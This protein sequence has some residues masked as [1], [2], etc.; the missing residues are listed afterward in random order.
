MEED[1]VQPAIEEPTPLG[2][3]K[4]ESVD[5]NKTAEQ[6][7]NPDQT[8]NPN[9][10]VKAEGVEPSINP[11]KVPSSR[12]SLGTTGPKSPFSLQGDGID[13]ARQGFV[14][15]V[16]AI[17]K[18]FS[19]VDP[20]EVGDVSVGI[21]DFSKTGPTK[22]E[23]SAH[24]TIEQ[25]PDDQDTSTT[26]R[27]G[28]K[29]IIYFKG[30]EAVGATVG[31]EIDPQDPTAPRLGNWDLNIPGMEVKARSND[32]KN[33]ME[34]IW[35]KAALSTSSKTTPSTA[36]ITK[37]E[38][39]VEE[40][41]TTSKISCVLPKPDKNLDNVKFTLNHLTVNVKNELGGLT[42]MDVIWDKAASPT[43]QSSTPTP[44]VAPTLP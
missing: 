18:D 10:T 43:P 34:L 38:C 21:D 27:L 1:K 40:T 9:A 29:E 30:E 25:N 17:K 31:N 20:D 44:S 41:P 4:T 36:K 6:T 37:P 15:N 42:R 35:D 12:F 8:L 28:K 16:Q 39:V 33:E 22:S 26:E 32:R 7:V 5:S 3:E 13:E 14:D 23:D 2:L 11:D 24:E 19:R